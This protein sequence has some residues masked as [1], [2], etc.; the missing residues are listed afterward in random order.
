MLDRQM[1]LNLQGEEIFFLLFSEELP[2]RAQNV[3]SLG[4]TALEVRTTWGL[5]LKWP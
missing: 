2:S 4:E 3:A 5:T 1:G